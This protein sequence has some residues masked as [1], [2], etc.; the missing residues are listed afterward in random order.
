MGKSGATRG[1]GDDVK[2]VVRLIGHPDALEAFHGSEESTQWVT[3]RIQRTCKIKAP[4]TSTEVLGTIVG[5]VEDC[6]A[7]FADKIARLEKL[8]SAI[9][10]LDDP[11]VELTLG[12]I[13]AD[14]SRVIH[15]LR[16]NGGIL[17]SGTVAAHDAAQQSFLEN[18]LACHFDDDAAAQASAGVRVGGLGLRTASLCQDAAFVASRI[19]SRPFVEH[20][21]AEMW[22]TGVHIDGGM[23]LYDAQTEQSICRIEAFLD[24]SR[25][26]AVRRLCE[27]AAESAALRLI[28]LISGQHAPTGGPVGI[29]HAGAHL[30]TLAGA[31]DD[32]HPM[33]D[34]RG[35]LQHELLKVV[36]E[37]SLGPLV[38]KFRQTGLKND[39]NRLEE[40]SHESVSHDWLWS[41]SDTP[42]G[43]LEPDEFIA[44]VRVRLG[45][46]HAEEPQLCQACGSHILDPKC[47]HALCC[48]PGACVRGH[49]DARDSLLDFAR[50]ADSTSEPEVLGL[51][52]SAPDLRPADI[53]TSALGGSH[54][55]ALDVGISSPDAVGAGDDCTVTMRRRKLR[56]YEPFERELQDHQI[57]YRPVVWSCYGREH[58]DT[59]SVLI[60]IARRAARRLGYSDF[61]PLLA[62][63]RAKIGVA[64]ARRCARMVL[65]CQVRLSPGSRALLC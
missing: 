53:L 17:P 31:E 57:A 26:A 35:R 13:C 11:Q 16:T 59:T 18:L 30:V 4:N 38:A 49:N 1:E 65:A 47:T 56:R 33:K 12:R 15:L 21:L 58:S 14:V 22:A 28:A 19:E 61:K 51:I 41:T 50:L 29:G 9:C 44:A 55:T 39:L 36:D 7:Q 48:A 32:E 3:G 27:Q 42:E 52:S 63:A 40:L 64:I 6:A 2:T 60:A 5:S 37:H 54:M 34:P 43:G 24:A 10:E 8:H 20:L 46:Q 25:A 45:A 62:R 23:Q